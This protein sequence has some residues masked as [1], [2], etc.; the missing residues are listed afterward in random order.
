MANPSTKLE[1]TKD[2]Q[3]LRTDTALSLNSADPYKAWRD[4]VA[5]VKPGT[6]ATAELGGFGAPSGYW[7]PQTWRSWAN[8]L[9]EHETKQQTLSTGEPFSKSDLEW[10]IVLYAGGWVL[11]SPGNSGRPT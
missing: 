3:P 8:L 2:F 1:P 11:E 6:Q 4:V 10:L 7:T 9:I 5:K